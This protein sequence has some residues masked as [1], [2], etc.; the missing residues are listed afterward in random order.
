MPAA[1]TA[2][3]PSILFIDPLRP[4]VSFKDRIT[5][6][7]EAGAM[8][9]LAV[10]L[11][12]MP[13]AEVTSLREIAVFL[14]LLCLLGHMALTG[15]WRIPSTPLNTPLALWVLAGVFSLIQAVDPAYTAGQ[16]FGELL[17]H[18]IVFFVAVHMVRTP[19]RARA[20]AWVVV[21]S[22]LFMD[23]CGLYEFFLNGASLQGDVRLQSLTGSP[24]QFWAWLI[25][26]GPVL[27]VLA[28]RNQHIK[29]KAALGLLL[30][31]HVFCLYLTFSR[32]AMAAFL[33]QLVVTL[34]FVGV[35]KKWLVPLLLGALLGTALFLPRDALRFGPPVPGQLNLGPVTIM[36][37]KDVRL[38]LWTEAVDQVAR[39]PFTGLGYG[40][41]S[42]IRS[43]PHLSR[44]GN[45]GIQHAHNFPL[46]LA[47]SLG[48]QGLV[49][50]VILAAWSIR[51]LWPGRG[52]PPPWLR[53]SMAGAWRAAVVVMMTGFLLLNLTDDLYA[54]EMA[55]MFWLML[56]IGFSCR[57][58][59]PSEAAPAASPSSDG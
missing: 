51:S 12:V 56:G 3:A 48:L 43:R 50:F 33:F 18:L 29:S 17:Y 40:R 21:V 58:M 22:A 34:Y 19:A 35:S 47:V 59:V 37:L 38:P 42:L 8:A 7:A 2:H 52:T 36:G 10:L 49:V 57:N 16:L 4:R 54:D 46:S 13:L 55:L 27:G 23:A 31:L 26:T 32:M 39:H 15:R 44:I 20:L 11:L 5:A 9:A 53:N 14:G 1:F 45:E 24:P 28:L 41:E 25:Q 30:A 6:W